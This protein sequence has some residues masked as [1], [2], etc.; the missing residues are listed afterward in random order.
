MPQHLYRLFDFLHRSPLSD[1]PRSMQRI[2]Q[3]SSEKGVVLGHTSEI[4]KIR[5]LNGV[6]MDD[7]DS[8][9]FSVDNHWTMM[10]T[11]VPPF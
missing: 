4:V 2:S 11:G 6:I 3:M 5:G 8:I 9:C 7:H 10:M 1:L